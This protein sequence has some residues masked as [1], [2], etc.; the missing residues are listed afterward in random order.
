VKSVAGATPEEGD[1]LMTMI[2]KIGTIVMAAAVAVAVVDPADPSIT[3]S[4][5]WS[6]LL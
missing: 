1:M 4:Y 2:M 6:C 3:V 5:A